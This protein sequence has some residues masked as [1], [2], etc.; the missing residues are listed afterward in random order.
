[1]QNNPDPN[2]YYTKQINSYEEL[3]YRI[4]KAKEADEK[5]RKRIDDVT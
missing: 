3:Q 5:A 2:E 1:M 4:T